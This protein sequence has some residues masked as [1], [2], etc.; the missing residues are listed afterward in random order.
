MRRVLPAILF[1]GLLLTPL[2]G[3]TVAT[4]LSHE[5]PAG[6]ILAFAPLTGEG[7]NVWKRTSDDIPGERRELG[8]RFSI[9]EAGRTLDKLVLHI[10][11]IGEAVGEGAA[12]APFTV[13]LVRFEP[14]SSVEP[15]PEPVLVASGALPE[16]LE[17]GG[18]LV[19]DLPDLALEPRVQ[20][21]FEIAF[22]APAPGRTLNLSA[23]G[24]AEFPAGRL[25][26][27][28]NLPDAEKMVYQ[29]K[30]GNFVFYLVGR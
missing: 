3:G 8:Q 17:P 11:A 5:S 10:S 18:Y 22:D 28:T 15:A 16:V 9:R 19:L 14:P 29:L 26:F 20:Y 6:A 1:S 7:N 4:S 23:T 21:G 2:L 27:H 24:K 25:Y 12:G 30:G 13:R